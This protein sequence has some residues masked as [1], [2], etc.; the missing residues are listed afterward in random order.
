LNLRIATFNLENLD[1]KPGQK[2]TLEERIKVM[3]P[4][5]QRIMLISCAF[6]KST[7]K[8]RQVILVASWLWMLFSKIRSMPALTRYQLW[9]KVG[10]R[11][12]E[13]VTLLS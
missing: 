11:F 2:P 5:L 1:N 6:R 9:T 7:V 4:Q 3:R 13:S 8:K 12:I 10:H